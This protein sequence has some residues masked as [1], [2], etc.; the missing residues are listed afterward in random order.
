MSSPAS[1]KNHPIHPMLVSVPIGLWIFALV[2]DV[3]FVFGGAAIWHTVA[4][5]C[6]AAGVVGA[7]LAAVPGFL[8]YISIDE[9]GDETH[10]N[11]P[12]AVESWRC[13]YLRN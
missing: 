5:Y 3:I 13:S 10:W 4:L 8:D 1:I 7:L 11:I 6:I 2:C 9:V 12:L